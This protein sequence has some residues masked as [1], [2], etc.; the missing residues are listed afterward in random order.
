MS[1]AG[2]RPLGRVRGVARRRRAGLGAVVVVLLLVG[3]QTPPAPAPPPASA[4][5][6][7]APSPSRSSP[8]AGRAGPVVVRTTRIGDR[9]VDLVVDS[10]AVG[11]EVH[12]RLLLPRDFAKEPDRTWPVLYLL[13][14]CCDDYQSWT[15]STDIEK[16]TAGSDVL[17]V[18][19]DGGA[20]GFYSDWRDGP[21]WE[22]FHL[23]E[24]P[25]LLR[26][27]YRAG[28]RQAIAGL[29]MGGLG[30]LGYAGRHPGRFVAAASFSGIVHTR[31][32][33]EEEQGYLELVSS[34]GVPD[35]RGLWGD[36][37]ADRSVW[38]EHNP[39]DL[40]SRLARTPLFVSAGDG[41]PGPLDPQ[42][43][44][45]DPLE[46]A[47]HVENVRF[48]ARLRR[49][50]PDARIDLYGAGTHTWPYWQRELHRAWPL[51]RRQL[52]A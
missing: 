16:L 35:P 10:P 42:G 31:L 49:V 47:I 32:S 41:R 48:A 36:P 25:G 27:G 11:A 14:G 24:L 23:T 2:M 30:A 44:A 19:P 29:S 50:D 33:P 20:V 3:C 45:P 18:M 7:V 8:P 34:Q 51:L 12:V 22:R 21:Q 9:L 26:T 39:Y 40:A 6:A 15:R 13:H 52:D 46:Q 28:E 38:Q 37:V 43:Q 17:V 1:G 4:S 5:P